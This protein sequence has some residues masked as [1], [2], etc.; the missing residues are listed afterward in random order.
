MQVEVPSTLLRLQD[1]KGRSFQGTVAL[2]L[3]VSLQSKTIEELPLGE[4]NATAALIPHSLQVECV[5][6]V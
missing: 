2:S 4:T 5:G 3:R 1:C 6:E